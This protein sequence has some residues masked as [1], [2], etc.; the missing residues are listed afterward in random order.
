[1]PI[2]TTIK[3]NG[4][5]IAEP[6]TIANAFNSYF[7]SLPITLR[8]NINNNLTAFQSYHDDQI[9][10]SDNFHQT[11]ILKI[12]KIIKNLKIATVLDWITSPLTFSKQ[13]S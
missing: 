10:E 5:N 13:M 11:S 3:L 9:P 2:S 8:D 7:N 12:T 1:M 4:I 6:E